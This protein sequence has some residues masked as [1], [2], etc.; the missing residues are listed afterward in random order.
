MNEE[1]IYKATIKLLKGFLLSDIVVNNGIYI[2]DFRVNVRAMTFLY[3]SDRQMDQADKEQ[4]EELV[5]SLIDFDVFDNTSID[6]NEIILFYRNEP[7]ETGAMSPLYIRINATLDKI[8]NL[9]SLNKL[10]SSQKFKSLIKS[11]LDML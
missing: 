9:V 5:D 8:Y 6:W 1:Q 4:L 11:K 10:H 7:E 2:V 3:D